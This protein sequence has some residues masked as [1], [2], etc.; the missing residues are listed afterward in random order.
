MTKPDYP[1]TQPAFYVLLAL[2]QRERHGYEIMKQVEHDSAGHVA[3]GPGTLYGIIKR[4]LAEGFIEESGERPDPAQDDERRRYYRLT[5]S[6]QRRLGVELERFDQA[7]HRARELGIQ[8]K[9]A[10]LW[11]A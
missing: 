5:A 7:L 1:L 11:L 8:V 3:M 10:S 9:G 6:G 2:H 4:Q